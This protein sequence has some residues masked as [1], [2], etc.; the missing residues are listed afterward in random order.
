M[1][2]SGFFHAI[3]LSPAGGSLQDSLR[4]LSL[5]FLYGGHPDVAATIAAGVKT[6]DV[7]TWLQVIP[8]LIARIQIAG[9]IDFP[10]DFPRTPVLNPLVPRY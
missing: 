7:D 5:W 10:L 6:V 4:L 2:V 9:I 1:A 8:Q 3:S